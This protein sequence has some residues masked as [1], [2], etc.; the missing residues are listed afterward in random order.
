MSVLSSNTL[1]FLF[2]SLAYINELQAQPANDNCANAITLTPNAACVNGGLNSSTTQ[3]GEVTTAATVC[4]ANNYTRSV[5]YSFTATSAQMYVEFNV[6]GI[7]G[8][9]GGTICFGNISMVLYNT[10]TCI[11]GSGSILSCRG[12]GGGAS[13]DVL[14]ALIQSGLTVGNNY[15]IQI[16]YNAGAGCKEPA[17]CIR[18]GDHVPCSCSSPCGTACIYPSAPTEAEL[19]A[20]CPYTT[21]SPNVDNGTSRTWCFTYT[22]PSTSVTG[23]IRYFVTGTSGCVTLS[24]SNRVSPCGASTPLSALTIGVNYTYCVTLAPA[25][26]NCFA[27][28]DV[29]VALW[30]NSALPINLLAFNAYPEDDH[31]YIEWSTESEV[32]NEKFSIERSSD[33]ELFEVIEELH[34]EGNS[35]YIINY[36]Y[37]DKYPLKGISYYRL[38]QTDYDGTFTFSE[39]VPV[40]F[41]INGGFKIYPN[42]VNKEDAN[43]SFYSEKKSKVT[44]NIYDLTGRNI[45][46]KEIEANEGGNKVNLDFRE[47]QKGVYFLTISLEGLFE[48]IKFVKE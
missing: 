20:T 34:G 18:V 10:S 48:K 37:I 26:T 42:P 33:G 23:T 28:E 27:G 22:A 3:T 25:A 1:F 21:N 2:F 13:T 31:V 16:G 8:G 47:F 44:F 24:G 38:R 39:I 12:N 41:N 17:F 5:W 30:D 45:V 36:D 15:L 32:N 29:K 40:K 11:P 43:L 14:Y 4:A 7:D 46:N 9:G 35:N 19:D 6:T